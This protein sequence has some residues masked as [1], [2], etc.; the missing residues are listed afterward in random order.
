MCEFAD[1][2]ALYMRSESAIGPST[3][4]VS[5]ITL[6]WPPCS[7]AG[8]EQIGFRS[9]DSILISEGLC[10]LA[11]EQPV[12]FFVH[13]GMNLCQKQG[14]SSRCN[15]PSVCL[16]NSC[17]EFFKTLSFVMRLRTPD[18]HHTLRADACEVWVPQESSG[19]HGKL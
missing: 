5:E 17:H 13:A 14:A 12:A 16:V 8:M 6:R 18:H 15:S 19:V 3:S 10:D 9:A 2:G 4:T 7:T 1:T 11:R